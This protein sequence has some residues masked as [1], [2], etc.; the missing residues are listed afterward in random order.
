MATETTAVIIEHIQATRYLSAA[1][2]VILLYDHLLTFD[3]EVRLI[4][5]AKT[6]LPKLLY[7]FNRYLVPIGMLFRTND[8]SGLSQT[9]FSD[10]Y[11]KW[12][13][14]LTTVL[15]IM[16]IGIS[17]FL[18][19]LRIWVLWD[20][21][22]RLIFLTGSLFILTQIAGLTMAGVILSEMLN[23]VIYE[24]AFH[25][26]IIYQKPS[27]NIGCLW[28]PGLAFEV[29]IFAAVWWNALDRPRSSNSKLSRAVY[30][31]GFLFFS[32]LFV[33]RLTNMILGTVAP[34]S[35]ILLGVLFIWS[36][37]NVTLSRLILTLRQVTV[38]A[39]EVDTE[40]L[41]RHSSRFGS[42]DTIVVNVVYELEPRNG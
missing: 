33:L 10:T 35:L 29:M 15:G 31:D 1:G 20:R 40:D 30:R 12:S 42:M 5:K 18:I 11:C 25:A 6:S 34:V 26:C 38:D 41:I 27:I 28:A 17:N 3:D 7:L 14:G 2:L 16:T 4:W 39:E 19:L 9:V 22:R 21:N 37:T 23:Y 24:Q 8:L 36:A 13:F 32:V